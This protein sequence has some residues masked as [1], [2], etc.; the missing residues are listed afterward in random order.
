MGRT[1]KF[2]NMGR[3]IS[4]KEVDDMAISLT[5]ISV[6]AYDQIKAP[7]RLEEFYILDAYLKL[8]ET[9]RSPPYFPLET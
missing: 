6:R 5:N 3:H 4:Y 2:V 1:A 9:L 7:I 8:V